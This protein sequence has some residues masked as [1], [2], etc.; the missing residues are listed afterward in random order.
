[1]KDWQRT[2]FDGGWA[3]ITWAPEHGG[4]GGTPAQAIIFAEEQAAFDVT[5]GYLD[6][7][8]SL[9]GPSLIRFGT[10]AQR[11]RY[12]RPMLRGDEVW[13][14]LFSEP[15]AGSDLA[16]VRTRGT[17]DGDELVLNGQKV[18][19]TSAQHADFGFILAR[20]NPDAPKHQGIT[21]ALVDMR[22][23]GV[24]VRPLVTMTG[25]RHFNEVFFDDVRTP[26]SNVVNGLDRGWPVATFV[27]MNEGA[28]IGTT[29]LGRTR[30]IDIARDA[31]AQGRFDDPVVRQRLGEA[32]VEERVLELLQERLKSAILDG[33]SPD[34]DGSVLKIL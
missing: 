5:S 24:E 22:Q 26:L 10:D 32:R 3:A 25:D 2:R 8:I 16:A 30:V 7:A 20:T 19:T 17:V 13:C 15:E 33:R 27:L 6:A 34:V 4:R 1:M 28:S 23:P 9:I 11:E 12:L 31:L 29:N 14:Q 21:F 18:W